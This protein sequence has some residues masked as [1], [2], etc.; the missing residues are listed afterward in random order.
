M[1]LMNLTLPTPFISESC[2]KTKINLNFFLTPLCGVPK[3]FMKGSKAFTKPFE[4]P[5][6]VKIK[7]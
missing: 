5:Q 3:G 4:A 7:I 1:T 6:S 2:K